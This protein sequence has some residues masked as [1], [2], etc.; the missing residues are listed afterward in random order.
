M[1]DRLVWHNKDVQ[2][3][4]DMIECELICIDTVLFR[5]REAQYSKK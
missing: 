5:K 4:T 2:Q 1:Q 3:L